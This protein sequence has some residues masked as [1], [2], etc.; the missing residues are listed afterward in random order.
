MDALDQLLKI[1]T[2]AGIEI[3]TEKLR[4]NTS[5]GFCRIGGQPVI[6]LNRSHKRVIRAQV[7][8][9][10]LDEAQEVGVPLVRG[11]E[12]AVDPDRL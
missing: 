6:F 1:A 7:L 9:R 11:D 4:G 3:R 8:Q 5:G 2:S 12:D 10:A